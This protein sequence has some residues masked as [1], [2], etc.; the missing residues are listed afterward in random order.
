MGKSKKTVVPKN[1]RMVKA[2][3]TRQGEDNSAR[4]SNLSRLKLKT[5]STSEVRAE[6]KLS[7][8]LALLRRREGATIAQLTKAT[9]W[10]SHSVRGAMSG[11]IKRKMGQVITSS[12]EEGMRI[13]RIAA[14]G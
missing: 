5:P 3:K 6:S 8:M 2:K 14:A 7:N 1:E 11:A 10:Q 9:G 12:K 4:T 13:Y